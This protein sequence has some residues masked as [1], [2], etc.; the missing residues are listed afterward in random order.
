MPLCDKD[1]PKKLLTL[2]S[3]GFPLWAPSLPLREV[4]VPRGLPW[5]KLSFHLQVAINRQQL[6]G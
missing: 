2:F 4:C 1:P 3:V 6:L 5:R